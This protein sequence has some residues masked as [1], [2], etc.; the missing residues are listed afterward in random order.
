MSGP[1]AETVSCGSGVLALVRSGAS[2]CRVHEFFLALLTALFRRGQRLDAVF[3]TARAVTL[4]SSLLGEGSA[5]WRLQRAYL[6]LAEYSGCEL[7]VC[8]RALH[9]SGLDPKA[10]QD[11]FQAA[12]ELELSAKLSRA[13][14]VLEY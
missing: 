14:R 10:L 11:N 1:V 9:S 2:A 6:Q 5:P 7:L 8:G 3:F 12:G 13:S 4:S